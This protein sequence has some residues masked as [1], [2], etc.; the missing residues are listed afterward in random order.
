MWSVDAVEVLVK[1]CRRGLD[2]E[3]NVNTVERN[4]FP[5]GRTVEQTAETN[6]AAAASLRLLAAV[7]MT[8]EDD[9]SRADIADEPGVLGVMQA[10][11]NGS[12]SSRSETL[13]LAG[14]CRLS[15]ELARTP[16]ALAAARAETEMADV[17][18]SAFLGGLL[19][20][21]DTSSSETTET[22]EHD[23]AS[24]DARSALGDTDARVASMC[25]LSRLAAAD[26]DIAKALASAPAFVSAADRAVAAAAAAS[27]AWGGGGG[28]GGG[29][30]IPA[31]ETKSD[32]YWLA[33][34]AACALTACAEALRGRA[35]ADGVGAGIFIFPASATRAEADSRDS[36]FGAAVGSRRLARDLAEIVGGGETPNETSHAETR[37]A[38][39]SRVPKK[40]RVPPR[41]D[42]RFAPGPGPGPAAGPAAPL[43]PLGSAAPGTLRARRAPPRW[44][45]PSATRRALW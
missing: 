5:Y 20:A 4:A 9:A 30:S 15:A 23:D 16:A 41:G 6:R 42:T 14:A 8:A 24:Y 26:G 11:L 37:E 29:A 33:A 19:R 25:A 18:G 40:K 31:N 28:G 10:L 39:E 38:V 17:E 1:A 34:H 36:A 32:I 22:T 43:P 21:L 3:K 35:S 12:A 27:R 2:V 7:A 44:R 45:S 13:V